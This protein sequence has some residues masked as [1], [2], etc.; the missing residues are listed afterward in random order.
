MLLSFEQA[1]RQSL[2]KCISAVFEHLYKAVCHLQVDF[3][4]FGLAP[5]ESSRE[6]SKY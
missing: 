4:L 5:Q 3:L 1:Q 2:E 6:V